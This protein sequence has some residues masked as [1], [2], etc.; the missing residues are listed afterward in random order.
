MTWEIRCFSWHFSIPIQN[1]T[2][3]HSA[4][5]GK[6]SASLSTLPEAHSVP[7]CW[8]QALQHWPE[9]CSLLFVLVLY[10]PCPA[11]LHE[12]RQQIRFLEK[13]IFLPSACT[14]WSLLEDWSV[15]PDPAKRGHSLTQSPIAP[16]VFSE[17]L[18][19]DLLHDII[20]DFLERGENK[21]AM[22]CPV[23]YLLFWVMHH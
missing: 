9:L 19:L 20:H 18:T 6:A 15:V 4:G 23:I 5:L 2:P 7:S 14:F 10:P 17:L 21:V 11:E 8:G 13:S 22:V 3:L 16:V 12:D 1:K